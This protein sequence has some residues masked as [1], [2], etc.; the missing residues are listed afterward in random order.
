MK[1]ELDAHLG[2]I[3]RRLKSPISRNSETF[4]EKWK[5]DLEDLV[6][7]LN[8]GDQENDVWVVPDSDEDY[9][10]RP[11][12][13]YAVLS[14]D[15]HAVRRMCRCVLAMSCFIQSLVFRCTFERAIDLYYLR[16]AT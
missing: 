10:R 2:G 11:T 1:L 9:K 15:A 13:A 6:A 7:S 16:R 12:C 5:R 3:T 4:I 14:R 8:A